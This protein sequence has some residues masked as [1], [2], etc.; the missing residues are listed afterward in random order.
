MWVPRLGPTV[1]CP[2]SED[3]EGYVQGLELDL[4]AKIS[5]VL[6]TTNGDTCMEPP[7]CRGTGGE[8]GKRMGKTKSKANKILCLGDECSDL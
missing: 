6:K 1:F 5:F 3:A 7:S 4:R 8:G 2:S